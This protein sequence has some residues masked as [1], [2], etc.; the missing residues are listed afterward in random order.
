M[1]FK[2]QPGEIDQVHEE[3]KEQRQKAR[4]AR[5]KLDEALRELQGTTEDV[6]KGFQ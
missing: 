1:W 4:D 6:A 3:I 2:K 5:R